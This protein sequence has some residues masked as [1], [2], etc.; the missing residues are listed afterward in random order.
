MH[1]F[2][3]SQEIADHFCI[4][5]INQ[6]HYMKNVLHLKT[7]DEVTILDNSGDEYISI[8]EA[9][10]KDRIRLIVKEKRWAE[11]SKVHLT[12]ACAIPKRDDMDEI[13]D[14]LTQLEV[15]SIIPLET[16]R[17]I[18]R[19]DAVKKEAR[20]NRWRKIALNA[21]QQ[22]QRSN[23]PLIQ[24]ITSVK[25]LILHS[26]EYRLK[27]I[28]TLNGER[29]NIKEAISDYTRGNILV[30]IGPEGDFTPQEVSLAGNNG[31]IS[32]SLGNAVLRVS[33]AAIAITSY[34]KIA[35]AA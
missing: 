7:G 8:I 21:A 5:D 24:E 10:E 2:F 13:I 32:V 33:T 26:Q 6:L 23:I 20:L 22:S 27:L 3:V 31:F 12:I 29:K 14:K 17:T 34:I 16:D 9:M 11:I 19:L 35:L 1:R 18:V 15:N 30:L 4:S 25:E 28:A